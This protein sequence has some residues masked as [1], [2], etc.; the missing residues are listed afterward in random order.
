MMPSALLLTDFF[1][2]ESHN[3]ILFGIYFL[4]N[5]KKSSLLGDFG[6]DF[7]THKINRRK[8]K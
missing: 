5:A 3:E 1:C 2:S 4:Y 6:L 8:L 7:E